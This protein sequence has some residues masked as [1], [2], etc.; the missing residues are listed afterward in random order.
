MEYMESKMQDQF[1]AGILRQEALD[2]EYEKFSNWFLSIPDADD[3]LISREY[4][5]D[6]F[7]LSSP[8]V[9]VSAMWTA[10]RA[11]VGL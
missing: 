7:Y 8:V 5:D 10:W 2:S 11:A 4:L 1:E 6:R 9:E 3:T